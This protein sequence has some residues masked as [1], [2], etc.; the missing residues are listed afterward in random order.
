MHTGCAHSIQKCT[1]TSNKKIYKN[2][3]DDRTIKSTETRMHYE[4]SSMHDCSLPYV[5]C[6]YCIVIACMIKPV[7]HDDIAIDVVLFIVLS[8][9][10]LC[11]TFF[12]TSTCTKYMYM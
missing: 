1:E 11:R 7:G 9:L 8:S 5:N 4:Y 2:Q 3:E 10:D 6:N 12:I